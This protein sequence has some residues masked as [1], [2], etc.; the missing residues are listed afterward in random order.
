MN[1]G[2]GAFSF[3]EGFTAN[4]NSGVIGS[5]GLTGLTGKNKNHFEIGLGTSLN[6][7]TKFDPERDDGTD[8][9]LL[10]DLRIGYRYQEKNGFIFRVGLGIPQGIYLSLGTRF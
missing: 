4:A 6:I 5:V 9:F 8:T 7:E 1:A 10:P 3:F 2:V